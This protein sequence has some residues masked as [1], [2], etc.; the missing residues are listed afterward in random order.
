MKVYLLENI[1]KIGRKGEVKEV[2][3]GYAQNFLFPSKKAVPATP[4]VLKKIEQEELQSEKQQQLQQ[5]QVKVLL[6]KLDGGT[7]EIKEKANEKGGLYKAI[8]TSELV[9]YIK[10]QYNVALEP[11]WFKLD[12]PIKETGEH[13]VAIEALGHKATVNFLISA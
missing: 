2:A 11:D 9:G 3:Q 13:S 6:E 5:T 12:H 7:V 10:E 1:K 4:D 8:G